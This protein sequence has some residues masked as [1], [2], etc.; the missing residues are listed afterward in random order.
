MILGGKDP[1]AGESTTLDDLFRRAGVRHPDAIA[2]ADPPN[3]AGF[4]DGAPRKL[5]FAQADRAISALA[6]RLRN[7]G[8]Q[9]DMVVAFQLPNTVESVIALLG[10][11]RAGM[12]AVPLP[13]LW[14]RQEMVSALRLV[15]AK[16]IVSC[17]RIKSTA[18]ST[19]LA[20]L[21]AQV[22][23]ELFPIRFI[24]GFGNALPDGVVPLD[25][26][27]APVR[28]EFVQPPARPGNAAAHVAVVTFDVGSDGMR[29]MARN[30]LELI[31]GGIGPYLECG[32]PL[33]SS[34]VS[35]VPLGSFAGV[36]LTVM[37]WLLGGGTL[38]LHHA[39]DPETFA[40]QCRGQDSG[41]VVLP[42]PALAALAETDRLGAPSHI[43]ALWR[44]PERLTNN[45]A[46]RGAAKLVDVA[47]LG[48][49]G[50]L[51]GARGP[52]GLPLPI[53]YGS[54]GAPRGAAATV[55]VLE[56]LRSAAGTLM[57]RGPM[58]PAS[59][60]PPGAETGP[61][62]HLAVDPLG[63]VETGYVCRL[64]RDSQTLTIDSAPA[65]I[66]SVGFYR[67]RQNQLDGLVASINPHATIVAVPSAYLDARLGGSTSDYPAMA[68]QLQASGA[69]PLIVEAFRP[70]KSA[71]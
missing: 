57:L 26:I 23:V 44:S 43:L 24:C 19:S 46:W 53:P 55:S 16:A 50:L 58:V 62:A 42:G 22:A 9:T 64:E 20:D 51:A 14:R 49:A 4:T 63:F 21:A 27:F 47:S 36:A 41:G 11:L 29:A 40:A 2:L 1:T 61:G 71:A 45:P 8:L 65:A 6:A 59:A 34:T 18:Q 56:A 52:D 30:H 69:N 3:R 10:I 48:E 28:P 25:D 66:T 15:G 39:F 68:A 5:T 54:I 35:A 37:P 13:L 32:A 7:L 12:I 33:D 38:N 31:A 67:F 60:F 17:A 70:R